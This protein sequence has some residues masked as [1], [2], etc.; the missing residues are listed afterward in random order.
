LWEVSAG[1]ALATLTM[2]ERVPSALTSGSFAGCLAVSADGRRLATGHPDGT[3]LLWDLPRPP[4][5]PGRLMAKEVESL[6]DDLAGSD[7]A[8]AWLA[9]WRLADAPQ[10]VQ[11]FLAARLRPVPAAPAEL[12]RKLLADLDSPSFGRREEALKR[13]KALGPA[14]DPALQA[15]LRAG[16]SLEQKKRIEQVLAALAEPVPPTA[17]ELR[18]LRAVAVLGPARTAAARR[19]LEELAG[20][21]GTAHLT[22]AARAA[23]TGGR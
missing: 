13:L 18:S 10:D 14:A 1:K 4:A 9:V 17:E 12:T 8:R 21:V 6:W 11:P 20:G 5:R 22:R 15:A 16:P 2:P 19:L 3:I 23:L 7:A